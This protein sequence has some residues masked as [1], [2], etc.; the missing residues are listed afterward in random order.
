MIP[1]STMRSCLRVE[2]YAMLCPGGG[3]VYVD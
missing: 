3:A 2:E 1:S